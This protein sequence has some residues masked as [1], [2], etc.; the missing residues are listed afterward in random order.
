MDK[1]FS[2]FIFDKSSCRGSFLSPGSTQ[3]A[4]SSAEQ[5]RYEIKKY[6]QSCNKSR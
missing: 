5:T 2:G 4:L 6:F 3:T 1:K